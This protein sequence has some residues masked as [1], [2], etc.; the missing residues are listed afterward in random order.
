MKWRQILIVYFGVFFNRELCRGCWELE[1]AEIPPKISENK[2]RKRYRIQHRR[3]AKSSEQTDRP[4]RWAAP[5]MVNVLM[6]MPSFSRPAS[7]PTPIPIMLRPRPSL[8][9]VTRH[10]IASLYVTLVR[11]IHG[12]LLLV[13]STDFYKCTICFPCPSSSPSS[14]SIIISTAPTRRRMSAHYSWPQL[15]KK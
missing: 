8:P 9:A 14:A 12:K 1:M 5:P 6:K 3:R 7:A 13:F 15:E 4:S 2:I 11:F 10:L